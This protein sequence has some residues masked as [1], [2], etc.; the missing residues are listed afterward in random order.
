[1]IELAGSVAGASREKDRIS[2]DRMVLKAAEPE[3]QSFEWARAEGNVRGVIAAG[4][5]AAGGGQ[6]GERQYAADQGSL[7]F[8]PD[9]S[10]RSLALTGRPASVAE[11]DRK[12]FA[13][14]I[15]IAFEKGRPASARAQGAVRIESGERRA[16]S[17]R[18]SLAFSPSGE[19]E[20]LELSGNVSTQGEGKSARADKAVEVP[21]RSVWILTGAAGGS[22]TVESGDSRIS[23]TTIE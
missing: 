21:A 15:D 18:A 1:M 22:A 17:D 10:I 6:P 11:R 14:T 4:H 9:G 23:A 16:E 3:A 8:A 20:T 7:L 12:V 2:C 5:Q 19:V 13:A